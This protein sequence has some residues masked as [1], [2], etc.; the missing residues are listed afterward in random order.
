MSVQSFGAL[1]QRAKLV[2]RRKAQNHG[3]S[4]GFHECL[5]TI[6]NFIP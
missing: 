2:A 1:L 3:A 6:H 4:A 5:E